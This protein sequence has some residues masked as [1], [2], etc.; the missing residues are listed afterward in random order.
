MPKLCRLK[1]EAEAK[2]LIAN[3]KNEDGSHLS[4]LT[5]NKLGVELEQL[6]DFTQRLRLGMQ[7]EHK[8]LEKAEGS[9]EEL[10]NEVALMDKDR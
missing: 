7:D 8:R 3:I 10:L 6:Q 9:L 5:G 1:L 4:G 2:H